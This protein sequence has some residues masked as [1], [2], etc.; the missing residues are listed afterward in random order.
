MVIAQ[1]K[2]KLNAGYSPLPAT[3][4]QA[5]IGVSVTTTPVT[6]KE[7]IYIHAQENI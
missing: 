5:V 6:V 2:V 4:Q 3:F 1:G 7:I